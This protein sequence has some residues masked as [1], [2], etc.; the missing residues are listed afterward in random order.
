MSDDLDTKV[1]RALQA[2]PDDPDAPARLVARLSAA[3]RP[4]RR[5]WLAGGAVVAG[6][7]GFAAAFLQGPVAV[8]G[9]D[10]ILIFLG[11]A[12]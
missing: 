4:I 9:G 6:V 8:A 10:A 12:L 7:A 11:G 3:R 1:R 5:L 2:V